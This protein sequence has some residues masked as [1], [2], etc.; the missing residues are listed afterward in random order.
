MAFTANGQ[1]LRLGSLEEHS[2]AQNGRKPSIFASESSKFKTDEFVQ[3]PNKSFLLDPYWGILALSC[4]FTYNHDLEP[5]LHR[6]AP[7]SNK[8]FFHNTL[9][10][11]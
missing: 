4:F 7:V 11:D 6:T 10:T 2:N 3:V 1:T 5:I 8:F 9:T